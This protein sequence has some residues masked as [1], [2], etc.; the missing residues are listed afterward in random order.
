MSKE[1]MIGVIEI[2]SSGIRYLVADTDLLLSGKSSARGSKRIDLLG[3]DTANPT[4][5]GQ[6]VTEAINAFDHFCQRI[7]MLG[8]DAISI[9]CTAPVEQSGKCFLRE[10]RSRVS[11][12]VLSPQEEAK[13]ALAAGFLGLPGEPD[14]QLVVFNQGAGNLV[15]SSG[16]QRGGRVDCAGFCSAA[17]GWQRLGQIAEKDTA[18]SDAEETIERICGEQCRKI[19]AGDAERIVLM[20]GAARD[21]NWITT[22]EQARATIAPESSPH[23]V[24]RASALQL[25]A[26]HT[27]SP[28]DFSALVVEASSS[29]PPQAVLGYLLFLKIGLPT[30][31]IPVFVSQLGTQ[32]GFAWLALNG[33]V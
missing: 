31:D 9:Y 16:M 33:G 30:S 24:A 27:I 4:D 14:D 6:I 3:C 19:T 22:T 8:C 11:F 18:L 2:G 21:F 23:R 12:R 28:G 29:L 1:I 20:G 25:I 15:I 13:C 17:L 32:H 10:L 26:L 5:R 7:K